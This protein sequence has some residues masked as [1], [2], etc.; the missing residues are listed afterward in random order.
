MTVALNSL[1]CLPQDVYNQVGVEAAQLRLDDQNLASGQQVASTA[2]AAIGD[3][4]VTIAALQYPM[5][6][7]TNL[8]FSD[9]GMETPVEA[10][11]TAV[12]VAG[13]TSLT[14]AALV[15]AI[16]S[17]AVAI[18]NGV[19][20]WLAGQMVTAC[21]KATNLIQR[22]CTNRYNV[23]D[24]L[25]NARTANG[26][27][28]GSVRDWAVTIAAHWLSERLYRAAPQ[29]IQRAYDAT[30]EELKAV[31]RSELDIEE[32]GTRTSGWPA[33]SAV[34]VDQTY[35]LSKVRVE[36]GLSEPTPTQFAQQVDWSSYWLLW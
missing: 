27:A 10:T 14:V 20:V 30:V 22:Y 1:F 13:A 21:V 6:K 9:A 23:S 28:G 5:L 26:G 3:L 36:Y 31:K 32:I 19:N 8:V 29:Q 18:D 16:P 2:A 34:T 7:G 24:L 11:L 33:Y 35:P 12:A 17:G 15:T 25:E 4:S